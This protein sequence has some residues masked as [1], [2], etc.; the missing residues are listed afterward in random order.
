MS[1]EARAA[2]LEAPDRINLK[3][4]AIPEITDDTGLLRV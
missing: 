1:A 2:V 3:R 4:F